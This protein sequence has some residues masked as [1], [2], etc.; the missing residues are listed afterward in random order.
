[1]PSLV[2]IHGLNGDAMGTWTHK[3]TRILWLRD[4]L[5]K[6]LPNV[7]IMTYGYNAAFRNFTAEQDIRSI[8]ASLLG[9]LVDLRRDEEVYLFCYAFEKAR[10]R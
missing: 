1:M 8:S 3:Q 9:E 5:P 2:A 4:L 6:V 7:R 10:I